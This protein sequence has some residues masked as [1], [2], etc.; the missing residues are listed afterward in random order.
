VI[1]AFGHAHHG[2]TQA[3]ATGE[4]VADLIAGRPSATDLSPFSIGRF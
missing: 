3:A 2:L 4:I 1:H